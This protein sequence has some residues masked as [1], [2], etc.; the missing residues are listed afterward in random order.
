MGR[1]VGI[2]T[3]FAEVSVGLF[4]GGSLTRPEG[5]EGDVRQRQRIRLVHTFGENKNTLF[6]AGGKCFGKLCVLSGANLQLVRGLDES[7]E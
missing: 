1:E 3:S 2:C 7:N 6:G 5:P 4:L